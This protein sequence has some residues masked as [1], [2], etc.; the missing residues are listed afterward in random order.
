MQRESNVIVQN[1]NSFDRVQMTHSDR[2]RVHNASDA[3]SIPI[4]VSV[5]CSRGAS[6]FAII[7]IIS[8][9]PLWK[10]NA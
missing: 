8:A 4:T 7:I 6:R 5:Y 3:R 10:P 1:P 9:S 2:R